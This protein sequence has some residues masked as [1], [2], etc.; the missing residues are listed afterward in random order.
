[1]ADRERKET[2]ESLSF[3]RQNAA[4][5]LCTG[6][7][8]HFHRNSIAA[9]QSL[10]SLVLCSEPSIAVTR[11]R[12]PTP[13]A[14]A[15]AHYHS[16]RAAGLC[17][18][19]HTQLASLPRGRALYKLPDVTSRPQPRDLLIVCRA[20]AYARA[21]TACSAATCAPLPQRKEEQEAPQPVHLDAKVQ[22]DSGDARAHLEQAEQLDGQ[23]DRR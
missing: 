16:S 1:M 2:E 19:P 9:Q 20:A 13:A 15:A 3:P 14:A 17:A 7:R 23:R 12:L 21:L 18:A 6:C 11:Q 5:P 10:R 8:A 22:Q 4:T